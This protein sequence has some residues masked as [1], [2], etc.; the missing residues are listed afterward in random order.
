[1]APRGSRRWP[2]RCRPA[3]WPRPARRARTRARSTIT[4]S[5]IATT[6]RIRTSRSSS[7]WSGDRRRSTEPSPFAIRPTSEAP[8]I[9]VTTPSPRPPTTLVPPYAIE[10]RATSGASGGSGSG[11]AGSGIDSPVRMLRSMTRRSARRMRRS[12]AT[13]SPARSRTMS[14]GT[15]PAAAVSTASPSRR[16]RAVGADASR[17]ASSARSPRYSVTTSAA[18]I[19][20]SASRTRSPSRISPRAMARTPAAMSRITNGSVAASRMS[21][22]GEVVGGASSSFAPATSARC[23]PPPPRTV[24]RRGRLRATGPRPPP[25]GRAARH[26][27]RSSSRPIIVQRRTIGR[28]ADQ[29][30]LHPR[31]SRRRP[32]RDRLGRRSRDDLRHRRPSAGCARARSAAARP[33]C[34][35]GSTAARP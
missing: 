6:N 35:A 25:P 27:I 2:P 1:M 14:P 5:P 18:T 16:T 29:S 8:P 31:R 15:S 26:P 32:T 33:G 4:I 12:A 28:D 34:P 19:G 30:C 23:R 17:N 22:P 7:D 11:T 21:R 3:G 20:I 10:R 9:A 13:M 24:R